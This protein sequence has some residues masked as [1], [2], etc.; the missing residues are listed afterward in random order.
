MRHVGGVPELIYCTVSGVVE[1]TVVTVFET[2]NVFVKDVVHLMLEDEQLFFK[3]EF[4]EEFRV[5]MEAVMV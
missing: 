5:D 1:C 2:T 4:V 3:S